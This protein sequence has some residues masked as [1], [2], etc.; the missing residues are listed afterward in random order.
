MQINGRPPFRGFRGQMFFSGYILCLLYMSR[1]I[2]IRVIVEFI[3]FSVVYFLVF[4]F[5][6]TEM[7]PGDP[8]RRTVQ[9]FVRG[10]VYFDAI[11]F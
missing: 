3:F 10:H 4:F 8:S 11:S 5:F 6:A 7:K 2:G 9:S 1:A